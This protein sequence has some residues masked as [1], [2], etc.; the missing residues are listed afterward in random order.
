MFA[1]G[2]TAK[3]TPLPL[4]PMLVPPVAVVNQFIVF[5]VD[6]AFKLDVSPGHIFVGSDVTA[7]GG[8]KQTFSIS[9][10]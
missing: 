6:V 5:P 10:L 3:L 1:D 2:F 4:A 7:E 8:A 9:C